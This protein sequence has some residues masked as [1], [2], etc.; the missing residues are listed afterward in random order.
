MGFIYKNIFVFVLAI[1]VVIYNEIVVINI[2]NLGSDTKYFLDIKVES[3]E[4]FSNTNNPA[5]MKKYESFIEFETENGD[6]YEVER[7][8]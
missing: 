2:C 3:D 1:G 8:N 4:L 7:E 5:I 6:C